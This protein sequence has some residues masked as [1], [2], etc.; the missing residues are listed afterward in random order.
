VALTNGLVGVPAE[1]VNPTHIVAIT[2]VPEDPNN[3]GV[4]SS[5]TVTAVGSVENPQGGPISAF[6]TTLQI[7]AFES[8]TDIGSVSWDVTAGPGT[9]TGPKYLGQDPNAQNRALFSVPF[10][11]LST[12]SA[13]QNVTFQ[14]VAVG[15]GTR[16]VVLQSNTNQ[17]LTG[18]FVVHLIPTIISLSPIPSPRTDPVSLVDVTFNEA[19]DPTTFTAS[20]IHLTRDGAA[21]PM[22]S[23]PLTITTTD[24]IVFAIQGLESYTTAFGSYVLTVD[25]SG[26]KDPSGT[27]GSGSASES[28]IV[29]NP[30]APPTIE[31]V[32]PVTSPRT[33]PVSTVTAIFSKPIEPTTLTT[34]A[35][36][37]IRDGT[38][39]PLDPSVVTFSSSD[40][41]VFTINGLTGYTTPPGNYSL[42]VSAA[43]VKD[44]Q[45]H[46]GFGSQS[47]S[48]LV[49]L[50][51]VNTGPQVVGL[52]RFG[53]HAN[54]TLL[55]LTFDRQLAAASAVNP[56]NYHVFAPG[57]DGRFGTADDIL[58]PLMSGYY[59]S[60]NKTVTLVMAKPLG[61]AGRYK[62]VVKGTGPHPITDLKGV[63]LDGKANGMPGSDF[64]AVFGREILVLSPPQA[65]SASLTNPSTTSN[66]GRFRGFQIG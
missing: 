54:P 17:K 60:A 23:P 42:T 34:A 37:L 19:I 47:I 29:V 35:L 57:R 30:N 62:I 28:F 8:G 53:I 7:H 36:T 61:L 38:V 66:K 33:E 44:S 32:S 27:P 55:V 2:S 40:N 39:V 1:F 41:I 48:F 52:T 63:A 16:D 31:Q 15:F 43:G 4:V 26:V 10:T 59:N 13:P 46:S 24:N 56:R 21:V 3:T 18:T 6:H 25:A 51:P 22:T 58:V 45:G 5:T 65:G 50:P 64:T 14:I 20:A 11:L 12:G 49:E 9:I